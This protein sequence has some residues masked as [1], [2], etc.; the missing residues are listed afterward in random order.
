MDR[1]RAEAVQA[2]ESMFRAQVAVV[3]GLK[4]HFKDAEVTLGEYD[5]LY[6]LTL[7]PGKR[8]RLHLLNQNIV[9]TQPSLSRLVERMEAK[10]LVRREPDPQD[11]RGTVVVLTEHGL[12][13]QRRVGRAHATH[14]ER[15]MRSGLADDD[16]ATLRALCDKLRFAQQ[17]VSE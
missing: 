12:A 2:W 13:V 16:L 11:G 9:L 7:F 1:A 14:I 3:R 15:Y 5:V 4:D 8:M 6:N 17:D 10:R